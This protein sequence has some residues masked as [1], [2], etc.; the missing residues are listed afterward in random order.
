MKVRHKTN[1][2]LGISEKFNE[3]GMGEI[4]VGFDDGD[5]DSDYISNYEVIIEK[6]LPRFAPAENWVH[7]K[8]GNVVGYWVD[9]KKAFADKLLIC[10]NYSVSF[11]EPITQ[12]EYD[13]GWYD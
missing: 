8:D 9:M 13:R 4:I 7:D 11:R 10:D 2:H 3:H 5:M 6:S 1:K 12:E